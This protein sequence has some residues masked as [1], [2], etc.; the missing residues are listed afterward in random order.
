MRRGNLIHPLRHCE[1][2]SDVAISSFKI[3]MKN[4]DVKDEIL[5]R[6]R[7]AQ[8]DGLKALSPPENGTPPRR[9]IV[10]FILYLLV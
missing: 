6:E 7:T 9:G 8:D 2:R 5:M 4:K 3:F 10:E 1:E